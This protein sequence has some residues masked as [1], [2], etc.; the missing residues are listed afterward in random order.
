M[1]EDSSAE[2]VQTRLMWDNELNAVPVLLQ[3]KESEANEYL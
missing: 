3:E 2:G 1:W